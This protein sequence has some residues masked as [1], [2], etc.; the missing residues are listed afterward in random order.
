MF[1]GHLRL[2][3]VEKRS[4]VCFGGKAQFIISES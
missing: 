2:L 4:D 3:K 1:Q